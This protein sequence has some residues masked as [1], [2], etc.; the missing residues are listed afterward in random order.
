MWLIF[1]AW[2]LT[3]VSWLLFLIE[4]FMRDIDLYRRGENLDGNAPEEAL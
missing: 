1:I 3:G 4:A 2:P